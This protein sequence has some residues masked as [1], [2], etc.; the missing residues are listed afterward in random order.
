MQACELVD[1]FDRKTG[2]WDLPLQGDFWE[3]IAEAHRHGV[4]GQG[5]RI[6]I[7][8][9]AFDLQV[10]TLE[11]AATGALHQW[12]DPSENRCHG[13]AVA[14]LVLAVAPEASLDLYEVAE[15]GAPSLPKI[16]R[17]LKL[18]AKSDAQV[19]NLSLGNPQRQRQKSAHSRRGS[20]DHCD[21]CRAAN[22]VAASGKIVVAAVGNAKGEPFC[23]A[24]CNSVVGAG[25]NTVRTEVEQISEGGSHEVAE[26]LGPTY[27]Q[28]LGAKY[29]LLQPEGVL[30][31]SFATPLVAGAVG[32]LEDVAEVFDF[33]RAA[34]FCGLAE[35][36][37]AQLPSAP[38]IEDVQTVR[39]SYSDALAHLP[40]LHDGTAKGPGC[41]GCSI[42]ASGLYIN[43]GLFALEEQKYDEAEKLLRAGQWLL[44]FSPHAAANLGVLLRE[45]ALALTDSQATVAQRRNL[46]ESSSDQFRQAL[47]LRPNFPTYGD[48][49]HEVV[50]LLEELKDR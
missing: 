46:L 39:L 37:H 31:S 34:M 36:C 30:G 26:A 48:A 12:A 50:R 41:V 20:R 15:D 16:L 32:L 21:L 49:L 2:C 6:A 42:F 38:S 47:K 4:R 9:G 14:L 10:P 45:K 44:P 33:V 19:V 18:A 5:R 28:A 24:Q 29:E 7:I 27:E 25:F 8:D 11:A 3:A 40:H 35:I 1:H 23:P 22:A 17:A 43:A 13:T